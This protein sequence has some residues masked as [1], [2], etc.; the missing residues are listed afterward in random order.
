MRVEFKIYFKSILNPTQDRP[1]PIWGGLKIKCESILKAS[2]GGKMVER[3]RILPEV[4]RRQVFY[5]IAPETGGTHMWDRGQ[6]SP[7]FMSVSCRFRR[8]S[9]GNGRKSPEL[10]CDFPILDTVCRFHQFPVF[11]GR[12]I[13]S[14]FSFP[15]VFRWNTVKFREKSGAY[16]GLFRSDSVK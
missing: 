3:Q 10:F 1:G 9:T 2:S 11:F 8:K 6:M 14:D 15:M 7:D 16:T 5:R 4:L 13:G 12:K